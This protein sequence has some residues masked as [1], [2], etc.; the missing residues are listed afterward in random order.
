MRRHRIPMEDTGKGKAVNDN[1]DLP[2]VRYV[3]VPDGPPKFIASYGIEVATFT[4][5]PG[6]RNPALDHHVPLNMRGSFKPEMLAN[7]DPNRKYRVDKFGW[8][9]CTKK[10]DDD[11]RRCSR[12]AAN[13]YPFCTTHGARLHPLDR[14]IT[15][16]EEAETSAPM[17][18]YQLFLAKQITIDDLDDEELMSFGFRTATGKIFKPKNVPREM[19][20]AFTQAI[21]DR[22]L[23]KLKS[24]A[25]AAAET[26]SSI[27][28]DETVEPNVRIKAATEILDRTIGK[29]PLT[30]SVQAK[31]GFEQ[32]FEAIAV[33][34]MEPLDVDIVPDALERPSLPPDVKLG[35]SQ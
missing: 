14:L 27:M 12:K 1:D 28:I 13:R 18:R 15:E 2:E 11:G 35:D 22:S 17:S 10:L 5:E 32:V 19:V 30:V 34:P 20:Q 9:L 21:F 31:A 33:K 6:G 23:D 7:Y 24:N 25:L 4:Q 16:T 29:A 3:G 8:A 26:L